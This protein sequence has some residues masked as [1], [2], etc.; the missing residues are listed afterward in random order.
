MAKRNRTL[1]TRAADAL[2]PRWARPP[3]PPRARVLACDAAKQAGERVGQEQCCMA[4]PH[5]AKPHA[6]GSPVKACK[7]SQATLHLQRVCSTL[8]KI[9]A[10][11]GAARLALTLM[12]AR[13]LLHT[14]RPLVQA[15]NI[16][17]SGRRR[18][19]LQVSKRRRAILL[20]MLHAMQAGNIVVQALDSMRM[21]ICYVK[22]ASCFGPT[23]QALTG[24]QT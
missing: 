24:S 21:R 11:H 10:S 14:G 3:R 15:C 17:L 12:K 13:R 16:A 19:R 1:T 20:Y 18:P 7:R 2:W 22:R 6:R 23:Q 5:P 4:R 9:S 8:C